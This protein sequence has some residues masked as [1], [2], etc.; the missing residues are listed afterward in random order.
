MASS[1]SC[2][3]LLN[4][5]ARLETLFTR[6]LDKSVWV[7]YRVLQTCNHLAS[8][9]LPREL[10]PRVLDLAIRRMQDTASMSR[11]AAMQLVRKLVEF[12]P[13]GPCA[14]GFGG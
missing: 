13:Y 8:N 1:K 3:E 6:F 4:S 14:Q 11:K 5:L 2:F 12:H 10:W 9:G 7:R